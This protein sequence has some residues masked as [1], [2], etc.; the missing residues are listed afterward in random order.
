MS[1]IKT[2]VRNIALSSRLRQYSLE[3]SSL[4]PLDF[5]EQV[6]VALSLHP[7]AHQVQVGYSNPY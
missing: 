7:G 1:I 3:M 6:F 5:G 2:T 4:T